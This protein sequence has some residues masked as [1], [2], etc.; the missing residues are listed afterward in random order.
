MVLVLA[1]IAV[2]MLPF[3]ETE[4]LIHE[5]QLYPF[6]FKTEEVIG[7]VLTLAYQP[8]FLDILPLYIVLTA[9]AAAFFIVF[10]ERWVWYVVASLALYAFAHVARANLPSFTNPAGWFFNPLAWQ[11]VFMAGFVCRLVRDQAWLQ[12]FLRSDV[13]AWVAAAVVA[14]GVVAAAPWAYQGLVLEWRPLDALFAYADKQYAAPL[15]LLHFFC[16]TY[17]GVRLISREAAWDTGWFGAILCA[18]GQRALRC[19]VLAT[20]L[21]VVMRAVLYLVGPSANYQIF[22]SVVGVAIIA[23]VAVTMKTADELVPGAKRPA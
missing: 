15:R 6:V 21:S 10:G 16:A 22:V 20:L 7:Q 17:L 14:V 13:M 9:L 11:L 23:A 4:N 18:I 5:L 2:A 19:F 12:A 1:C 8:T 3:A